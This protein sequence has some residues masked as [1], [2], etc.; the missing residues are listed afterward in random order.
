MKEA[1]AMKAG[2]KQGNTTLHILSLTFAAMRGSRKFDNGKTVRSHSIKAK[3]RSA[4][5]TTRVR[6]ENN[7]TNRWL[8]RLCTEHT[9]PAGALTKDSINHQKCSASESQIPNP[10]MRTLG[11][12]IIKTL[13]C[14]RAPST[15][16]KEP[17][18][19]IQNKPQTATRNIATPT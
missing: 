13:D 5:A 10:M 18:T 1:I 12:I 7:Q 8:E 9:P 4:I 6:A 15:A 14:D 11:D 16:V 17:P 19:R 3:H 2:S